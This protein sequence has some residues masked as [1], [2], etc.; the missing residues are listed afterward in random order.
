MLRGHLKD[1]AVGMCSF[2]WLL[3]IGYL[4]YSNSCFFNWL[5]FICLTFHTTHSDTSQILSNILLKPTQSHTQTL[6]LVS[7]SRLAVVMWQVPSA[8]SD[9]SSTRSTGNVS[10]LATRTISPTWRTGRNTHTHRLTLF[11][12]YSNNLFDCFDVT[13]SNFLFKEV[14]LCFGGFWVM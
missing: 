6:R 1:K 4:V 11:K 8:R 7:P 2:N 9:D 10:S 13:L 14:I 12:F 5:I 3:I